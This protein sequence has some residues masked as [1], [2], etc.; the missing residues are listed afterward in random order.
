MVF[1]NQIWTSV[2]VLSFMLL[3]AIPAASV[4]L[5]LLCT[6]LFD[7][8]SPEAG[9]S[10]LRHTMGRVG[11]QL[12][13]YTTGGTAKLTLSNFLVTLTAHYFADP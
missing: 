5:V 9:H 7:I 10:Q 13:G 6:T 8:G 2:S 12:T 3:A 4:F 11:V 1:W